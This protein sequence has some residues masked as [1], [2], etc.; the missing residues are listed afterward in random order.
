MVIVALTLGCAEKASEG[1]SASTKKHLRPD[2][3]AAEPTYWG[4]VRL[5]GGDRL[6]LEIRRTEW[7]WK[8]GAFVDEETVTSACGGAVGRWRY[9]EAAVDSI[10]EATYRLSATLEDGAL[11][12]RLTRTSRFSTDPNEGA[13]Y[14]RDDPEVGTTYVTTKTDAYGAKTRYAT[15][16]TTA[17]SSSRP[18]SCE[19]L[20]ETYARSRA[21]AETEAESRGLSTSEMLELPTARR[22]IDA[23]K[24]ARSQ[25]CSWAN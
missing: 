4:A 6:C 25:N 9:I 7:R 16:R 23:Q 12:Y 19:S 11:R 20:R 17:P 2:H 21:Q 1:Q 8:V 22:A 18:T 24:Q 15:S 3:Q 14:R 13:A 10:V 5:E